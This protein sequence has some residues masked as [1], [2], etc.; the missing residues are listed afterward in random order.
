MKRKLILILTMIIFISSCSSYSSSPS[1]TKE[2]SIHPEQSL[3]TQTPSIES[4]LLASNTAIVPSLTPVPLSTLVPISAFQKGIAFTAWSRGVYSLPDT[5]MV[6]AD[7]IVPIGANWIALIVQCYQETVL[8]MEIDCQSDSVPSDDELLSVI[9]IAHADGLRVMLKPGI[10]LSN[11]PG[12]WQGQIDF[13]SDNAKWEEW[14]AAYTKFILHYAQLAQKGGAD[15]FIVGV[16]LY[17][18]TTGR[19][20]AKRTQDWRNVIAQ[21]RKQFSGPLVYAANYGGEERIIQFWDALEYIG[22]DAYYPLTDVLHPTVDQLVAGWQGPLTTLEDLA[23]TWGKQ[24]LFTEIGYRSI[25]GAAARPWDAGIVKPIDL[26]IQ[27]NAYEAVFKVFGDKS[28]WKGAYWWEW[29]PNIGQGG[30]LNTDYIPQDKPA[31]DILR[32]YYG[33][34]PRPTPT[35]ILGAPKHILFDEAHGELNSIS[36][37]HAQHLYPVHPEYIYFGMLVASLHDG[38]IFH[39]NIDSPLTDDLLK[40]Y[41]VLMISA[42][43]YPLLS[44]EKEAIH[45]FLMNGGGL[46]VL[47]DSR[48]DE[49][50][51]DITQD[52]GILFDPRCIYDPGA[53]FVVQKFMDQEITPKPRYEM[54][55]GESLTVINP[56]IALAFTDEKAWKDSNYNGVYDANEPI[57]TF[58]LI[59][60]NQIGLGRIVAIADNAF[61]DGFFSGRSNNLIMQSLLNWVTKQ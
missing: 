61:Q 33:A 57:G 7:Q 58:A 50:V 36:W 37:D 51:N 12:H 44:V 40:G 17:D 55:G 9:Q 31:E 8:S 46:V 11:D 26:Q 42:P 2:P 53:E 30:P 15:Q 27:A 18:S 38:Y 41:D 1:I 47:G 20:P 32:Y 16:E 43:T 23:K 22:V 13:G 5:K 21:V 3:L 4:K 29:S 35:A 54:N 19:G 25:E 6:L 24:I 52:Y 60:I 59:A 56:A 48:L 34:P 28:W 10:N 39:R 49:P 45:N 14:F